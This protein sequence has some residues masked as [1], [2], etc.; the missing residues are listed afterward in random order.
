MR[1]NGPRAVA[2]LPRRGRPA[3]R[4]VAEFQVTA[5]ALHAAGPEVLLDVVYN[6]VGEGNEHGPT[7][8]HLA[9]ARPRLA[10]RATTTALA[11]W[12]PA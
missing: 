7:L 5:R 10:S 8:C 1:G 6:H 3:R 9:T 11:P 12:A 4:E 2:S